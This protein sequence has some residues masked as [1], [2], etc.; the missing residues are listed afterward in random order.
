MVKLSLILCVYN[1]EKYVD[2]AISS[3]L[4][5][6]L[7]DIELIIVNDGSTD[8]TLDIINSYLIDPRIKIINQKNKGLG[9]A[10]NVG[11]NH[12]SGEY[13]GFLDAD[14]WLDSK[15]CEVA[16]NEA[17]SNDTDIT[18][19]KIINQDDS[20]GEKYESD[21]FN[22]KNLD[23]RFDNKVFSPDDTK[24]VLFDFS[25]SACQK[26]Y[27]NSFLKEIGAEFPEGIYFEDMPFFYYVYLNAER[28]SIIREHLYIRRKHDSSITEKIDA[29]FL[30]TVPAGQIMFNN[31]VEGGFY[32]DY[33]FDLIAYKVNGP[34]MALA[35][36]TDDYKAPLFNLIKEDYENIRKTEY[37]NDFLDNLGP[38]KKKFFLD[39]LKSD[40]YDEFIEINENKY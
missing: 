14:D 21:W 20:T 24:D 3:A 40:S 29:K 30:D 25:V 11:M 6:S 1:G 36:I 18:M 28:I 12:A 8:K 31:F 35:S 13:I 19:F 38:K 17:K 32:E 4:D 5:Q 16:Y 26:I 10:R 22:L 34:R 37:Y 33:K 39:M 2:E 27:K 9:A 15:M 23:G 7:E